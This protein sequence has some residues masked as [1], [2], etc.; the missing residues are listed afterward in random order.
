MNFDD[1]LTAEGKGV[2]PVERGDRAPQQH[3]LSLLPLTILP[4][5]CL[6]LVSALVWG[7]RLA[8]ALRYVF[9]W[10]TGLEGEED[11]QLLLA[12]EVFDLPDYPTVGY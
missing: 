4:S 7:F 3:L 11:N 6:M 2:F 1:A 8:R 5:D 10:D 12:R 9:L